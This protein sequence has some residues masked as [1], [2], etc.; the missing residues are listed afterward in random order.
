MRIFVTGATGFIGSHLIRNLLEAGHEPFCYAMD[1]VDARRLPAT[2][3]A[4][5]TVGGRGPS[6]GDRIAHVQPDAVLHLAAV[7]SASDSAEDVERILSANVVF[8]G[9]VAHAASRAGARAFVTAGTFWVH[10][11][12]DGNIVYNSLY[13]ASKQAFDAV[14]D[15]YAQSSGMR[16]VTLELTDIY[17]P[18]DPRPKFLGLLDRAAREGTPL[19]ATPGDQLMS[20]L[21]VD[22]VSRAFI[23]AAELA[24]GHDEP[25]RRYSVAADG[26]LTLRE[27]AAAYC[28]ATGRKPDVRWGATDYPRHQIMFPYLHERLPGWQPSISLTA[29]LREV[30]GSTEESE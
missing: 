24:T 6:L 20:L 21:H 13:A 26:L 3:D 30:Y 23:R 14:L 15:Y 2:I 27:I 17:G 16:A 19:L 29:G 12:G 10:R 7:V 25:S 5:H 9:E 1:E 11:D 22:D 4:A 18:K 8:G 28:E